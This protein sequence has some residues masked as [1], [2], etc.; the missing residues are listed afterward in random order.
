MNDPVEPTVSQP[1]P[2]RVL[3]VDD[4]IESGALVARLLESAGYSTEHAPD[5]RKAIPLLRDGEFSLV[6]LDQQMPGV[7]G[8]KL[9]E[10]LRKESS[11][12]VIM[13]TGS[14][15]SALAVRALRLGAFDYL[16]KPVDEQRLIEAARL[17]ISSDARPGDRI[18]HYEID[19]ELGRGGMGVVY[20]ARDP[21]LDR[22][23][24]LKVL[25]P[26]FAADP[27]YEI[28]F[29]GEARSAAKFSHPHIVTVFEAGRFQ[30]RL[31]MAMEFVQGEPLEN[32]VREGRTLT[33]GKV[34]DIAL[35]LTSALEAMHG[36]GMVHRDL[37]PANLIMAG[38]TLKVLD[39]G[40][41]RRASS[42]STVSSLQRDD[43][44]GTLSYAPP[45][46]LA[47]G[48]TDAR[49]DIYALGVVMYELLLGQRAFES[50]A[51]TDLMH[52]IIEA[53]LSKPFAEIT[54]L[55]P[56]FVETLRKMMAPK[57]EWRYGTT[58]EVRAA[59]HALRRIAGD[60]R[61]AP[62]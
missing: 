8:L 37:K 1:R 46:L 33:P 17:A 50:R 15:K 25:L 61:A 9:L 58:A 23:V 20:A 49:G 42:N 55:P 35:Q 45:E 10:E 3:I 47:D 60:R 53:K 5:P 31:F 11:V 51:M 40:L 6:V 16:T 29:L 4:E 18:A 57:P 14:D 13:L 28:Q 26:E 7:D 41:V 19:R 21:R 2:V 44:A 59:L 30:G 39:F 36:A 54:T 27:S 38:S 12:P 32:V 52:R 22:T 24:A 34:L 56:E 62:R 43:Y 48:R